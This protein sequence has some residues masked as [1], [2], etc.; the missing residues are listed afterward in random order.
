MRGVSEGGGLVLIG[1]LE[2][3]G[4]IERHPLQQ[5]WRASELAVEAITS[6]YATRHPMKPSVD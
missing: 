4:V 6:A 5:R 3:E 1:E 2:V